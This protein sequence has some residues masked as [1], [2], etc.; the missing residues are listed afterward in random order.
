MKK[1]L[2]T[3][4]NGILLARSDGC[5]V[6]QFRNATGDGTMT[7]YEI[8]P[9]A[10]LCF[11]DFHMAHFD[12]AYT[13][14][15]EMFAIDHCREGKMEYLAAT[16][17]Y[18]YVGAGDI[19][20]DRRLTHTGRFTFPS[21]HY[22][23]LT[24]AFDLAVAA[25]ALVLEVKD[26]P[27]DLRSLQEKFCPGNYPRVLHEKGTAEHIFGELYQVPEKIRIPYFKIKVLELL[28]YLDALELPKDQAE[29]PYYYKTQVEKV[30]SIQAFLIEHMAENYT[31][32]DLSAR[33]DIPLTGMKNCFRSVYGT[34]IKA[35]LTDHRMNHAAELLRADRKKS[36]AEIA[37]LVGYDSTSKFAIAFRKIM[38]MSPL[39]YRNA[40][41]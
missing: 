24:V 4:E 25:D 15:R 37:G 40:I 38:G 29:P 23:G 36:V 22:H 26:F 32:D 19:K 20:L 41:R 6:Y 10:M 34:S 16:N 30:K 1:S 8:F 3:E 13:P 17:A 11:N 21:S 27:V 2:F 14:G 18:A 7:C 35:W 12:S 31:L 5:S 9:G 33:F 39:E 28:L